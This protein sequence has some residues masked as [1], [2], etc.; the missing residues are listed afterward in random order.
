[1]TPYYLKPSD[2]EIYDHYAFISDRV[3][4][5]IIL[6]NIP[7]VTGVS[8]PWW[9]VEALSG[10]DNIV[11]IKDS[12]GDMPY[13]MTLIEKVKGKMSLLCG[14][15]EVATLALIA[16][17]DG[18]ILASANI[19]PDVWVNIHDLVR[20][21]RIDDAI[22]LQRSIQT[23]TRL[24][25]RGGALAVKAALNMMGLDVGACR[26]PL[27]RGGSF[28]Y[29]DEDLLR[30][31]LY[32]LGKIRKGQVYLEEDGEKKAHNYPSID[33]TPSSLGNLTLKVG[34][35]LTSP[36]SV[37]IAHIDLILGYV[38]GPVGEAFKRALI[39]GE[40]GHK[41]AILS[42]DGEEVRPRTLL[43]PT[44][45]VLNDKH[46]VMVYDHAG[47]G[48]AR[49]VLDWVEKGYLPEWLVDRICIIVHVFVHPAA[50]NEGRVEKNNYKAMKNA[51]IKALEGRPSADE[52]LSQYGDSRH[53]FKYTP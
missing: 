53:P 24:T 45:R 13:F 31:H 9:V 28:R 32:K 39:E 4:I 42:L 35:S 44:V 27:S 43:I 52:I 50:S 8:I 12:S 11:G 36:G 30:H 47:R 38:D 51:L 29:E 26:H 2:K 15:D 21:N 23:L 41:P 19:I 5:P 17:A 16:G 46:K 14:H 37:D 6:Y 48:V 20:A 25:V 18:L 10:R 40:E 7:Q 34:E 22:A 3:D 1:V 33:L 49:A